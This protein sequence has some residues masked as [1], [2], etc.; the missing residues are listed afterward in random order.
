MLLYMRRSPVCRGKKK[1]WHRFSICCRNVAAIYSCDALSIGEILTTAPS[2]PKA[3]KDF[4]R[5]MFSAAWVHM[6]SIP[7]AFNSLLMVCGVVSSL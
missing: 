7:Y 1:Y 3:H 4:E 2:V 5:P 6:R